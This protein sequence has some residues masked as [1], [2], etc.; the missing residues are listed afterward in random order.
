MA[1]SEIFG[2]AAL[3]KEFLMALLKY[4]NSHLYLHY[5]FS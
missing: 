5:N 2:F 1:N 3:L 4:N